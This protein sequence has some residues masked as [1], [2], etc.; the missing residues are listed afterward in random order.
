M[1]SRKLSTLLF[2]NRHFTSIRLMKTSLNLTAVN[3]FSSQFKRLQSMTGRK[4][5]LLDS[6]PAGH[7]ASTVRQQRLRNVIAEL[8][9]CF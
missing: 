3:V 9:F 5:L 7:T 2:K 4:A 6:E 1:L 8:T